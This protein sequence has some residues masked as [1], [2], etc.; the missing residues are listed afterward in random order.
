MFC[1]HEIVAYPTNSAMQINIANLGCVNMAQSCQTASAI[2]LW[3]RKVPLYQLPD[4][5]TSWY[6]AIL[7]LCT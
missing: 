7:Y 1:L 2:V 3:W 4:I 6:V 5:I